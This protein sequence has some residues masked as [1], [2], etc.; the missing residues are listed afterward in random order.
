MRLELTD[1]G[2]W[3]FFGFLPVPFAI[4]L[5]V[6]RQLLLLAD[7]LNAWVQRRFLLDED[8]IARATRAQNVVPNL[9]LEAHIGDKAAH[10]LRVNAW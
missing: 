1:F 10:V 8:V 4:G 2:W 3:T 5:P 9:A 7:F 6:S